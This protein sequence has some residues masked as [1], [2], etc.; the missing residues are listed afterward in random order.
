[1][2][3][4][5]FTPIVARDVDELKDAIERALGDQSYQSIEDG[6]IFVDGKPVARIEFVG[7]L[8]G[9]EQ[10]AT[11][12][13]PRTVVPEVPAAQRPAKP[14]KAHSIPKSPLKRAPFMKTVKASSLGK[15]PRDRARIRRIT[16]SKPQ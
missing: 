3:G 10:P 6:E 4:H 2:V 5:A 7:R 13:S 1:M 14:L 12:A 11:E 15:S 8:A 9:V 16:K